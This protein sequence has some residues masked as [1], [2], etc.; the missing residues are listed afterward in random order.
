M[1]KN[2]SISIVKGTKWTLDI[3]YGKI[4][5]K[6]HIRPVRANIVKDEPYTWF[7]NYDMNTPP[8]CRTQLKQVIAN[9]CTA[10]FALVPGSFQL[11]DKDGNV[12]E[13]DKDYYLDEEYGTFMRHPEGRIPENGPAFAS[14]LYFKS[15]LDSIVLTQDGLCEQR[16][17]VE[18]IAT[19]HEPKLARGEKRLANIYYTGHPEHLSDDMI[20]PVSNI[21]MPVSP[22]CTDCLTK[23]LQKLKNGEHVRI[24]AWGDS[25]TEATYLEKNK[26]YQNIFA[27]ELQ[28]RF[29][30]ADIEMISF[31]W[32]GRNTCT[33]LAQPAG[34]QYNIKE[35]ILDL[36]P[37]L[38]ISEFVNDA[39]LKQNDFDKNYGTILDMFRNAGIEWI[40][41][42]PHYVKPSWMG[43]TEQKNCT[44]DPRFYVQYARKYA[45]EN[46][47]ALADASAKYGYLWKKGIPYLAFMKNTINHPDLRGMKLFVDALLECMGV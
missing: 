12:F 7:Q 39:G 27:A 6:L 35:H 13:R 31:G 2:F 4:S 11:T 42:T 8:W 38:V 21:K 9:E 41:L 36:K 26:R 19:P 40:I 16:I 33:F 1:K 32:G 37:D 30:N 34:S 25:V 18:D 5:Q 46:K 29:P 28:K 44:D 20:F 22:A 15:R 14:Y 47:I 10:G 3:R 24:I 23:T 45:A 17:G 43:L